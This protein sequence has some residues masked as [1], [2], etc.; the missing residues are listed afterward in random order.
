MY[1]V[2]MRLSVP[3]MAKT[4]G[5]GL[6]TLKSCHQVTREILVDQRNSEEETRMRKLKQGGKGQTQATDVR[7]VCNMDTIR[8]RVRKT[9]S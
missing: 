6:L 4:N 3:L 8:G 2:T 5:Q 1:H 7:V 9:N